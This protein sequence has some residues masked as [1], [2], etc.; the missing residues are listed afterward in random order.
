MTSG[1][2]ILLSKYIEKHLLDHTNDIII[3]KIKTK[4]AENGYSLVDATEIFFPLNECLREIYGSKT[5]RILKK[6]FDNIY[7]RRKRLFIIKD[8]E[9]VTLILQTYGNKDKITILQ[10]IANSQMSIS[11]ILQN[12]NIPKSS[13]YKIINSLIKD[14]FLSLT[15]KKIQNTDGNKVSTY[16]QTISSLRIKIKDQL[17]TLQIQFNNDSIKKSHIL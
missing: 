5:D 7:E 1:I 11:E 16:R 9:L 3:K 14:G 2:D 17:I 13:G 8:K 6:L 15:N 12:T 4:L 10:T